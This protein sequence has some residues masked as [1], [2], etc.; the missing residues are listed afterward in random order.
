MGEMI[1]KKA[2]GDIKWQ[3]LKDLFCTGYGTT[4]L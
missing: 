2:A 3:V 1:D 4:T